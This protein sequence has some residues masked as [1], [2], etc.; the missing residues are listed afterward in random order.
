MTTAT[1]ATT[2]TNLLNT[3]LVAGS[4]GDEATPNAPI[5]RFALLVNDISGQVA[6]QA[7]VTNESVEYNIGNVAGH[8]QSAGLGSITKLVAL[9]GEAFYTL[10]PPAVG[11][12]MLRF[13]ANFAIV[14]DSWDGVGG[15]TL[16]GQA[17]DN[18]RVSSS[19][20]SGSEA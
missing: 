1:T 15:W 16:G 2:A 12:F 20:L 5:L 9:T 4:A 13:Q 8:I 11:T 14:N 7:Q 10:R 18:V 17:V 19:V 6:G 3:Y